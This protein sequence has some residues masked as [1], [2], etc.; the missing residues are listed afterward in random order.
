MRRM[1]RKS[2]RKQTVVA[3][4]KSVSSVPIDINK[5]E[6]LLRPNEKSESIQNLLNFINLLSEAETQTKQSQLLQTN[7]QLL[8]VTS[9]SNISLYPSLISIYST[10]NSLFLYLSPLSY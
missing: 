1:V 2:K 4:E 3:F 10:T 5:F 9:P 6:S 7:R 8:R